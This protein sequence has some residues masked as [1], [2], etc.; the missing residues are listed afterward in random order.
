[1]P[2]AYIIDR[3]RELLVRHKIHC[4]QKC[5]INSY[6]IQGT[7]LN[8]LMYK[9]HYVTKCEIFIGTIS[10]RLYVKLILEI[11]EVQNLPL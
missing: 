8:R 7:D 4:E 9:T 1:M 2:Q 3:H 6:Q 11:L 5:C 10:L